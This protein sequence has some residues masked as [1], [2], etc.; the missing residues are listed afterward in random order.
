MQQ[1]KIDWNLHLLGPNAKLHS[2]LTHCMGYDL[3]QGL[4][5]PVLEFR[6]FSSLQRGLS[7]F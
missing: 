6:N 2:T 7:S 3:V 5:Q 1:G 4:D